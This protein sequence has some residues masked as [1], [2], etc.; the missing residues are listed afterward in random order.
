MKFT[1]YYVGK[2]LCVQRT[3]AVTKTHIYVGGSECVKLI[4]TVFKCK[5]ILLAIFFIIICLFILFYSSMCFS[6]RA[7]VLGLML[8]STYN[9]EVMERITGKANENGKLKEGS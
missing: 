5:F 1:K 6:R 2:G 9:H 3:V 8:H 4:N 7:G